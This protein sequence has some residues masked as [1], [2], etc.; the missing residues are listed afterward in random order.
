MRL[1]FRSSAAKEAGNKERRS[2][3]KSTRGDGGGVVG[4]ETTTTT[5]AAG[6]RS[7]MMRFS[8]RG[9]LRGSGGSEMSLRNSVPQNS[10]NEKIVE[11]FIAK[12]NDHE[13]DECLALTSDGCEWKYRGEANA[14][15]KEV[16]ET[17]RNIL[18]SFPD[19]S[20]RGGR[21]IEVGPGA[22]EVKNTISS[23][24]HTGEPFGFQSHGPVPASGTRCVNEP[25]HFTFFVNKLKIVQVHV[26]CTGPR[27]GPM[28]LH[29]QIKD[30]QQQQT[31]PPSS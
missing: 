8:L 9:S 19:F 14:T 23:G 7:R 3:I 27:C 26:V 28:G 30:A 11:E 1:L 6:G 2:V 10:M 24:T 17:F 22:V 15:I 25:E 13:I 31:A 29:K 4:G 20:I 18:R 5:T 12:L 21:A 16:H